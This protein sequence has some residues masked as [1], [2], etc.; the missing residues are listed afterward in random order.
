MNSRIQKSL[1]VY[2][3]LLVPVAV[4]GQNNVYVSNLAGNDISVVSPTSLSVLASI[5][6]ALGPT[7]LAVTPNGAYVYVACQSANVVSVISTASNSVVASIPVGATPTQL[8]MSPNGA[9]VIVADSGSNQVS[10]IDTGSNSVIATLGVGQKPSGIA[11]SP[12]GGRAFVANSYA[13]SVSIIDT[14]SNRVIGA[15]NVPGPTAIVVAPNGQR[16]YVANPG[17]GSVTVHDPQGNL[18]TTVNGFAGPNSLAI[19]PNGT[20]VFVSNSNSASAS[21]IDTGSNTVVANI[22]AST[23]PAAVAVSSDGS[24]AFVVNE[25]GFSLSVID[26]ASNA[27]IGTTNRVGVYPVGVA[28]TPPAI[29]APPVCIYQLS[30]VTGAAYSAAGGS[31]A[32]TVTA[33]AGCYW[34]ANSNAGW[35]TLTGGLSGSGSGTITYSVSPNQS[36]LPAAGYL[37]IAGQLFPV[38]VAGASPPCTYQLSPVTGA[39]YPAVGGSGAVTVT[40]GA[41]CSWSANN[42]AGWMTLTGGVSGSGSGAVPYSVSANQSSLAATGYLTIAGQLFPVTVAA[43]S[44][45]PDFLLSLSAALQSIIAGASAN[46]TLIV[47]PTGGFS[48][49]LSYTVSGLPS[50]ATASFNSNTVTVATS[51]FTAAGAYPLTITGA[52]GGVTHSVPA[53]LSVNAPASGGVATAAFVKTDTST[54][55]SWKGVYGS[56]G[57]AVVNDSTQY[58]AYA[59]VSVTNQA[60]Y[61]WAGST[62]NDLRTLQKS[63]ASDR[64]ASTWYSGSNFFLDINLTDGQTH[65]VA[66][67]GLD[68]DYGG[69][70]ETIDI[71]NVSTGALLDT[72]SLTGFSKGQYLV[73]NL[74]GHVKIRVTVTGGPNAVASGL[75]FG[76]N[77]PVILTGST[78][79]FVKTDTATQG[80]WKGAYGVDGYGVANDSTAYPSYA[81][82][83][84]VNQLSYTWAESTYSDVRTLQKGAVADRIASTWYS[85]NFF[86]D[87]N[88]MDGK[89]HPVS[90][91]CLDWDT[92]GRI[93][94]IDI[95]DANTGAVLD[96]RTVT[97][98]SGGKYVVWNLTG[99]VR[100][101]ATANGGPNAVISG[102]FFN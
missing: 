26:T 1:G 68:W 49:A 38:T 3:A 62:P 44:P 43:A 60:P 71:L 57:Y 55:G 83:S 95:L 18:V 67:Y 79:A 41:G 14:V 82:V 31:G 102:L 35:I 86:A 59:Q 34:N 28:T 39:A 17:A 96:S 21:V 85:A 89:S 24:R 90:I 64:I 53:T 22:A 10:I 88:L 98:F 80:T 51:S 20:R 69:R 37:T 16:V 8:A 27:V 50:G 58:P 11:F 70:A 4:S 77:A 54:Q 45:L 30:P 61:T 99:H 94:T 47:T 72:R 97:G 13:S 52:G 6:V 15:F 101:R 40:A 29:Q 73:W 87:I 91:Y 5:P 46:C 84:F 7:G 9:R 92:T 66:L 32:V 100:I 74:T 81:Q 36:V 23:L 12:D 65:Q 48:S 75:F 33:G 93:Q 76:G 2:V 78:A 63:A 56:D 25:Y 19:T 42:S